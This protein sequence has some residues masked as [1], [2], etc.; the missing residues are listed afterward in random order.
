[1]FDIKEWTER[2][3][4]EILKNFEYRIEFIGIQGSYARGE[5]TENS[6]IDVVV[7]FDELTIDDLQRYDEVIS[8]MSH[9]DKI[10]GFLSGKDEIV[11][12]E[13]SD[14]FQFYKDTKAIYK[15]LDFLIPLI[16]KDNVKQAVLIGACNIYHACCHN[17]IHEKDT[18][19][20]KALYKQ[21]SFVL[22]AKYFFDT[23]NYI[24]KKSELM[25]KLSLADRQILNLHLSIKSVEYLSDEEFKSYSNELFVWSGNLIK[26]YSLND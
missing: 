20:L 9:R 8:A 3:K 15:N 5:A 23:N 17:I 25:D 22:Q 10:C 21:A 6:D 7:I 4:E 11:N 24:A 14:L 26:K 18:E 13:K 2:F 19:I 16:K 12:W 1:M